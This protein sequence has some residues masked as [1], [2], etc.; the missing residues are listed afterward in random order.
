MINIFVHVDGKRESASISEETFEY[1]SDGAYLRGRPIQAY[2]HYI[3]KEYGALNE[4]NILKF[5]NEKWP[6]NI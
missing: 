2:L 6:L 4:E 1:F 5:M 3:V